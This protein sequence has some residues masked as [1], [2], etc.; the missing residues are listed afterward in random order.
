MKVSSPAGE[1]L[2]VAD[3]NWQL[4]DILDRAWAHT[5]VHLEE[6]EFELPTML[7][8]TAVMQCVHNA[9]NEHR[10]TNVPISKCIRLNS[11]DKRMTGGMH[12]VSAPIASCVTVVWHCFFLPLCICHQ[13]LNRLS[14]RP[15]LGVRVII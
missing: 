15:Q 13:D 11:M 5:N 8:T 1:Y 3:T 2:G 9:I 14:S 6:S 12:N 4:K 10:E 7:I